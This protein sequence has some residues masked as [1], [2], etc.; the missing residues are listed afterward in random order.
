[1]EVQQSRACRDGLLTRLE[2]GAHGDRGG[3]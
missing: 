2:A 3:A 1:V